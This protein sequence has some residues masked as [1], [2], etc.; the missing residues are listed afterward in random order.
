MTIFRLYI[1][2]ITLSFTGQ[3][4][5]FAQSSGSDIIFWLD[6]S[7]S[8]D[9]Y[10]WSQLESSVNQIIT[11]VLNCNPENRVSVVHYSGTTIQSVFIE[12]DFTSN[13][14][15][16]LN[17]ERRGGPTGTNFSS[18]GYNDY[19]HEA[20]GTIGN[21]LDGISDATICSNQTTLNQNTAHPLVIYYFTDAYR[22][23]P[24]GS[25]I[26]NVSNPAM[27]TTAAF[28]NYMDFKLNRDAKFVV[29][30]I[31]E[32]N[33]AIGA[34]AS[35]SSAGGNYNGPIESYPD[36]PDGAGSIP[37][38]LLVSNSFYLPSEQI[39]N[40]VS[41]L[42]GEAVPD[43]TANGFQNYYEMNLVIPN[44]I[45][46]SSEVGND[47][48]FVTNDG[49]KEFYC[50]IF[51][52]W[53][54]EVYSYNHINGSWDGTDLF[55]NKVSEGVYFYIITIIW[56]DDKQSDYQGFIHVKE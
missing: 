30:L 1:L 37:R 46:L 31:P 22:Y 12:S 43:P 48:F 18:M 54:N 5:S 55:G 53:G 23:Q 20:L 51:N 36:D 6:N 44:V 2:V 28:Y 38:C 34:C 14:S 15:V 50:S 7:G 26:V 49:V 9:D 3:S 16:A 10:E 19:A 24:A 29:T 39:Q 41:E 8:V 33:L 47:K 11:G 17:Y 56:I 40:I 13:L 27:N 45:S 32:D 42:C 52:R 21:A 4:E 35:I 25:T